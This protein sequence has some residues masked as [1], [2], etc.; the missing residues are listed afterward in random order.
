[1]T[2]DTLSIARD[3]KAAQLP[4]GQAEAI[5]SAIGHVLSDSMA[6]KADLSLM[7]S[8]LSGR[9][10]QVRLDL[11]SRI[12]QVRS[13]LD[14]RIEQVRLSLEGKIERLRTEIEQVRTEIERSRNQLLVGL[15]GT[16]IALAGIIIAVIK[17]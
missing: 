12:E 13:D 14:G 17:L 2:I 16:Q 4:A 11:G 7:R 10:E 15:V 8:D 9:I 6:T 1:M 5:A 3:L